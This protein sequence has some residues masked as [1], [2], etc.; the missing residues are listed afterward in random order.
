MGMV[1]DKASNYIYENSSLC[2]FFK[3]FELLENISP[4]DFFVSF[5]YCLL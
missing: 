1:A 5:S 4:V 2:S 3:V